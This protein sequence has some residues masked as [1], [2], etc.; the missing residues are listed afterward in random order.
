[1][2]LYRV[3]F[4]KTCLVVCE[5]EYHRSNR[6]HGYYRNDN[7]I[8]ISTFFCFLCYFSVFKNC[9]DGDVLYRFDGHQTKYNSIILKSDLDKFFWS[10]STIGFNDIIVNK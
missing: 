6:E 1:M 8:L 9:R 2:N 10:L 7:I 4:G 5:N 3:F